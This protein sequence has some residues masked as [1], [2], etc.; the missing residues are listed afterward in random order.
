MASGVHD[1]QAVSGWAWNNLWS[2]ELESQSSH[3]PKK[4]IFSIFNIFS[5][6]PS[7][8]GGASPVVVE[9]DPSC[10]KLAQLAPDKEGLQITSIVYHPLAENENT[11]QQLKPI[12]EKILRAN[13]LRGRG[14]VLL[15]MNS[16][17]VFSCAL[18]SM[19]EAEIDQAITWKLKQSL[20]ADVAIES[21]SSD[22]IW[23]YYSSNNSA[24]EIRGLVFYT[25]RSLGQEQVQFY[26]KLPLELTAIQPHPYCVFLLLDWLEMIPQE[27]NVLIIS[28]GRDESAAIMVQGGWPCLIRPLGVSGNGFTSAIAAYHRMD[29]QKAE[30]LK[31]N[32]GL[33]CSEGDSLCMVALSGQLESLVVELEHASRF[34]PG[35]G[36]N[37][38]FARIILCGQAAALHGLDKFLSQKLSA[39]AALFDPLAYDRLHL[40]I[41]ADPYVADNCYDF[42]AV[43]GAAVGLKQ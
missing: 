24:K 37:I 7:V 33:V 17:R 10:I 39:Q 23:Q 25:Q 34:M 21:I 3:L 31:L 5:N 18:P 12:L 1:R 2:S 30:E 32:E 40:G 8:K 22:Y 16:M 11:P 42:A 15:P 9:I 35:G 26:R 27:E 14:I 6:T 38:S 28:I 13:H 36:E 41:K 4:N 20:P 43:L 19:P 29:R